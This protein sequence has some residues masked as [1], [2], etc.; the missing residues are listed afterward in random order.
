MYSIIRRSMEAPHQ[1]SW[2][3][4]R[5]A[6]LDDEM[7][8]TLRDIVEEHPA[9]TVDQINS[10]LRIRLPEKPHIQRTTSLLK[11]V[12]RCARGEERREDEGASKRLR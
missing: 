10:E 4:R 9:F 6:K 11:E 12:R 2:G 7:R 1:N 5:D 3:S 8:R